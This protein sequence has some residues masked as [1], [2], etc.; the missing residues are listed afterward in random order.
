MGKINFEKMRIILLL[1]FLSLT[2]CS[3]STDPTIPPESQ[4]P[5]EIFATCSDGIQNG[6]ETG[7]DCGGNCS[8]CTDET[9]NEVTNEFGTIKKVVDLMNLGYEGSFDFTSFA[10]DK[11]SNFWLIN[12]NLGTLHFDGKNWIRKDDLDGLLIGKDIKSLIT[13]DN[14]NIAWSTF[15]TKIYKYD[16]S[17][18]QWTVIDDNF[19]RLP[20]DNYTD[21][22]H[23][24]SGIRWFKFANEY[25]LHSGFSPVKD[26]KIEF[27]NTFAD[28]NV[29]RGEFER[30][31]MT[32]ETYL[33]S[34]FGF[35]T[36]IN[37]L[38]WDFVDF[39]DY[40]KNLYPIKRFFTS[41]K[42]YMI[43][44]FIDI[45]NNPNFLYYSDVSNISQWQK[46]EG[47]EFNDFD[48]GQNNFI[49][50]LFHD[51]KDRIWLLGERGPIG[52]GQE[53]VIWKF[54]PDSINFKSIL[55]PENYYIR[56]LVQGK[57][58]KIYFAMNVAG[59]NTQ[60]EIWEWTPSE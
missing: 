49:R 28:T 50:Q 36:E 10:V 56:Y 31:Y 11:N 51:D 2:S 29:K 8:A 43:T 35:R 7:I 45:E 57:D 58:G 26:L 6:N 15:G 41:N 47:K 19:N 33:Y 4:N 53:H 13:I 42:F 14:E 40:I 23:S 34:G 3:N 17:I 20:S 30:N 39:P 9:S 44:S 38:E 48:S 27:S 60:T 12:P 21:F 1:I 46:K 24:E 52:P 25:V 16:S 55:V 18:L 37:E 54:N 22:Y 59:K 5:D 32:N